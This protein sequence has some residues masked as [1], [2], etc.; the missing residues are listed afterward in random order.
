MKSEKRLNRS[1][2]GKK[3]FT[4]IELLVVI[5]IIAILASLLLPAVARAKETARKITCANNLKQLGLSLVMYADDNDD[6]WPARNVPRWPTTLF[7]YYKNLKVLQCP[8][9]LQG[10]TGSGTPQDSAPRSFLI[11]GVNDFFSVKYGQM[12][13]NQLSTIMAR[14]SFK[15]SYIN[16]TTDTII[17]GEKE[18]SSVH[19]FMDF[20]E[21]TAGNDFEEVEHSRHMVSK[22]GMAG[23]GSN[24]AFADGSVRYY[25]YGKALSP[26]N[27]WAVTD[28]F[29]TNAVS[30]S[31]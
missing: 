21:T 12:N 11:N 5:A 27:L 16:N 6:L 14:E 9:D 28:A 8:T 1:S 25:K 13:F 18:S 20:L 24:Y 10:A 26:Q 30:I 29:R 7:D 2:A 31:P 23:G 17:F 15:M 19:Y 3:A 22:S 4:L